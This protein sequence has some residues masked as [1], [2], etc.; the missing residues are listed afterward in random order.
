MS[1]QWVTTKS[2]LL[3][4]IERDRAALKT[5]LDSLTPDQLTEIKDVNG[6]AVK[7]HLA[8]IAAW[9]RSVI[10]FLTGRPRHEALGISEDVYILDLL[11]G[12]VD[13][14]NEAI[15]HQ[16]KDKPLEEIRSDFEAVHDE[17]MKLVAP[18]DDAALQLPY[19]HYLPDEPGEGDGPPAINVIYGN[20]AHHFQEHRAWIEKLVNG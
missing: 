8:H 7:D 14:A 15:F 3:A 16:T 17:L 18:L 2:E 6:W 20:T 5:L 4:H 13:V 1:D 11:S 12:D 10:A 19:I 9:E